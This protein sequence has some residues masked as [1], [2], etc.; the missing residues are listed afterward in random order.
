[1]CRRSFRLTAQDWLSYLRALSHEFESRRACITCSCSIWV[2]VYQRERLTCGIALPT[3]LLSMFFVIA[4]HVVVQAVLQAVIFVPW[5][6]LNTSGAPPFHCGGAA[7]CRPA[8]QSRGIME[9]APACNR[10]QHSLPVA[11]S[12]L[13][14]DS[15]FC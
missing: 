2:Q 12:D 7:C 11:C 9:G 3:Q 10:V 8:L 1:M 4:P 14:V 13:T 6:G 15:S 5:V